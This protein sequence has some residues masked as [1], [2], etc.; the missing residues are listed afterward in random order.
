MFGSP[1]GLGP[2]G[3]DNGAHG[4]KKLLRVVDFTMR[5]FIVYT[6]P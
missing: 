3:I 1:G 5:N 2:P 4:N 6:M